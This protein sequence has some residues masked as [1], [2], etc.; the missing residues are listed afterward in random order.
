MQIATADEIELYGDMKLSEKIRTW[1]ENARISQ[2]ELA[3]IVGVAQSTLGRWESGGGEP[4]FSQ[5]VI[6]ARTLGLPLSFL[7]DDDQD[8]PGAE[9][10][11]QT[12]LI[13]LK[14][15]KRIGEDRLIDLLSKPPYPDFPRSPEAGS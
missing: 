1:R 2:E 11:S 9:G 8:E 3:A 5:A 14:M 6:L 12:D 15:A 10:I 4:K 7:A 13:L